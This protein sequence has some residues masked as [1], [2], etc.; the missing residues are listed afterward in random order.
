M[1]LKH[2]IYFGL[3][4][5]H[6]VMIALFSTH[7]ADWSNRDNSAVKAL[8]VAGNYTGSNNIFSFF[9]PG[10]SD[11]PYVVY[12]VK[13]KNGTEKFIDLKGTSP[14]FTN[15]INNIYGYLTLPEARSVLSASLAQSLLQHYPDA[16]KI[17]VA[18]VIQQIPDMDAF[19]NGERNH[20][21]FWFHRDFGVDTTLLTQR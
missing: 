12:T 15:R 7:F 16:E 19:R 20:W 1:P 6:L 4:A 5:L 18:M 11:Q 14:D 3:A 17:R 2:K 10:L 13:Y 8:S 9:A 21:E